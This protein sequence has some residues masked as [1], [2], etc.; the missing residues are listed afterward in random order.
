VKELK[1]KSTTH[2][3]HSREVTKVMSSDEDRFRKVTG[4]SGEGEN[5][6]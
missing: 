4:I 3:K 2:K 6:E 5:T 1:A